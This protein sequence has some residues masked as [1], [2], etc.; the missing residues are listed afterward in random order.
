MKI[1]T[2]VS[3]GSSIEK[4]KIT[5]MEQL[6]F[7][8]PLGATLILISITHSLFNAALARLPSPEIYLAGFTVAKSLLRVFQTPIFMV[9]QTMTALISDSDSYYKVKKFVVTLVSGTV[10][11]FAIFSFSGITRWIF[12]NIMGIKGEILTQADIIIKVFIVFPVFV[13]LRNFMQAIAIKFKKTPLVTL[14]SVSRVIFVLI[15]IFIVE[16]LTFIPPGILAGLMFLG[17]VITEA[18]TMVLGVRLSIKDIPKSFDRLRVKNTKV[19]TNEMTNRVILSFFAPL[20]ATSFI[21]S[22]SKPIIDSG[23]ARTID[24]K[25]A[26]SAYAVAWGIGIIIVSP[27]NNFHQIPLNFISSDCDKEP[28]KKFGLMLSVTLSSIMAI[29]AFTPVGSYIIKDLIGVTGETLKMSKDVLKIMILLPPVMIVRQYYWGMLMKNRMTN[30]VGVGKFVNVIALFITIF[31]ITLLKPSNPA[32]V[33]ILGKV[34]SEF[35]ESLFLY[36]VSK[37]RSLCNMN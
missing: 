11:I 2:C 22:L 37:K 33:G 10:L 30:Y 18:I 27:L 21:N 36:I 29:I 9:K 25:I 12:K 16:K 5:T 35:F 23:L 28:V 3:E 15:I 19:K 6:S 14:A 32:V 7:F 20:V 31:T 17:A 24:P 34:S 1:N 13:T 26:I 4:S 8:A